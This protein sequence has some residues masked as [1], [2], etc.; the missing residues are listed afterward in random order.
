MRK[1]ARPESDVEL[2]DLN[3]PDGAEWRWHPTGEAADRPTQRRAV[4]AAVAAMALLA[5]TVTWLAS[6]DA[7]ITA[8]T[9]TTTTPTTAPASSVDTGS[10]DAGRFL[11]TPPI[12]YQ[13]WRVTEGNPPGG[14][15]QL[16]QGAAAGQWFLVR[17][18]PD[19]PVVV[20]DAFAQVVNG[21][22]AYISQ[23]AGS[24]VRTIRFT[25]VSGKPTEVLGPGWSDE[26]LLE[27][28]ASIDA[29]G[30]WVPAELFSSAAQAV[31]LPATTATVAPGRLAGEIEYR[32]SK[33]SGKRAWL[34]IT[35]PPDASGLAAWR[36]LFLLEPSLTN[37]GFVEIHS[38]R[39]ATDPS[40]RVEQWL[41][42]GWLITVSSNDESVAL[43]AFGNSVGRISGDDW[44]R[45][46]AVSGDYD[47]TPLSEIRVLVAGE[48]AGNWQLTAAGNGQLQ[49][50]L[51]TSNGK[52]RSTVSGDGSA[53]SIRSVAV[54]GMTY[55]CA[56][57]T[58]NSSLLV[59]ERSGA[60]PVVVPLQRIAAGEPS[61]A[62]F[63]F[64]DPT[65][66]TARVVDKRTL[67]PLA[68][69]PTSAN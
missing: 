17:G 32:N 39:L 22:R 13:I 5:G 23:T 27:L 67:T 41:L 42:D 10:P 62:V 14:A 8:P 34:T 19:Q 58:D 3:A 63:A 15:Q 55:V 50:L 54:D 60:E 31:T 69:W 59:V 57:A 21:Q 20:G 56:Y 66:F 2:I 46:S 61:G 38:G 26:Q 68:E 33:S 29:D 9:T 49:F 25:S 28:A 40:R 52:L 24:A 1:P 6:E 44:A 43:G 51:T 12:G 4:G 30:S 36:S 18:A 37:A 64:S 35:E 45:L 53:P 11:A 7:P 65:S 47:E 16:V 48:D